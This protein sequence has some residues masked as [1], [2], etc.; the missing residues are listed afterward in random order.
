MKVKVGSRSSPWSNLQQLREGFFVGSSGLSHRREWSSRGSRRAIE[1]LTWPAE[2]GH[3]LRRPWH[4]Y[5]PDC[6]W[7]LD[8]LWERIGLGSRVTVEWKRWVAWTAFCNWKGVAWKWSKSQSSLDRFW[9]VGMDK[10]SHNHLFFIQKYSLHNYVQSKYGTML[11][12]KDI[13]I[14]I[15]TCPLFAP[16]KYIC[17]VE[18]LKKPWKIK[19][20]NSPM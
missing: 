13:Y 12:C 18:S 15:V 3:P 7:E 9:L 8:C 1:M 20:Y 4:R 14:C 19:C 5:F 10:Y 11:D 16:E 2:W 6:C 17:Y